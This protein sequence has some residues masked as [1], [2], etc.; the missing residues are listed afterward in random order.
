MRR[1]SYQ[2]HITNSL[3]SSSSSHHD[4]HHCPVMSRLYTPVDGDARVFRGD[5]IGIS[6]VRTRR[7]PA[8]AELMDCGDSGAVYDDVFCDHVDVDQ[9]Q[10]RLL[11]VWAQYRIA[12]RGIMVSCTVLTALFVVFL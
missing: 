2:L 6:P 5:G 1:D 10:R 9:R 3:T 12:Q 4:H 8:V 11:H 7:L